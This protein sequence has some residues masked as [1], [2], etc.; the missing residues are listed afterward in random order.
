M[1]LDVMAVLLTIL[2]LAS[3]LLICLM[4]ILYRTCRKIKHKT[5]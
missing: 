3:T 4:R 2:L 1:L 5:D